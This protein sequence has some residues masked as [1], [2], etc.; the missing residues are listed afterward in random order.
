MRTIEPILVLAMRDALACASEAPSIPYLPHPMEVCRLVL[1]CGGSQ[2]TAC[3]AVLHEVVAQGR[4]HPTTVGQRYGQAVVDKLQALGRQSAEDEEGWLLLLADRVSHLLRQG[5]STLRELNS[6]LL[7]LR[8]LEPAARQILSQ[9]LELVQ[10]T[11][12]VVHLAQK[13]RRTRIRKA[14]SLASRSVQQHV[15]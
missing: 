6:L 4:L 2:L 1:N 15:S 10:V 7:S 12:P 9:Q 8:R 14:A 11:E 13:A 5:E 3:A